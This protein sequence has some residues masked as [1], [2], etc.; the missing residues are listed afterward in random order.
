MTQFE[1]IADLYSK[2]TESA[3]ESPAIESKLQKISQNPQLCLWLERIPTIPAC[4]FEM[5]YTDC[6]DKFITE[7]FLWRQWAYWVVEEHDE[8]PL[9]DSVNN[10]AAYVEHPEVR[11]QWP[12]PPFN[13]SEEVEVA[14]N[15]DKFSSDEDDDDSSTAF[16]PELN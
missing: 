16:N 14:I 6:L 11:K 3:L 13:T 8:A 7:D 10:I 5:L 9:I 12:A 2:L 1:I 4:F 15:W